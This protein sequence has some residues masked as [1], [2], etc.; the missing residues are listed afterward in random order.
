M[1]LFGLFYTLFVSG[2]KGI[3]SIQNSYETE[4]SKQAAIKNGHDIY[5][6]ANYY[7][8]YTLTDEKIMNFSI[9]NE[10][11]GTDKVLKAVGSNKIEIGRA[12]V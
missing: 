6:D 11:G 1:G 8:R 5:L 7:P 3:K 9:Q 2:A 10:A 4:S 12:H